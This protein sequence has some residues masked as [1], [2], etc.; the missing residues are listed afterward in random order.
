VSLETRFVAEHAFSRAAGAPLVAGNAVRL[1]R[2]ASENY[3]AWLDAIRAAKRSVLFEMYIFADDAVGARFLGAFAAKA[4]EGVAVRVAYDWVGAVGNSSRRQWR[5]LALAGV[6]VRAYNPPRL[7]EPL[8]WLSRDHRKCLVVDGEVAFVTGL[9]VGQ[10]W[11]GQP[12]RGIP[13]WRDTGVEVRGPAVADVV[14]AFADTWAASGSPLAES[15]VVSTEGQAT[16]GTVALRV[17]ATTSGTAAL[18]RLDTLVAALARKSLW[19]TDAYY[20]GTGAYVQA[21]RAAA[22]DGVDVRLLVPGRGS[23]IAIMQAVSRAGYRPLLEGGVRVFEWNGP[24]VHAKTA[25][26]DARWARVGSTNLNLA[27]WISNREL[28]V[29]IEDDAFGR[30]MEAQYLKDLENTTEVV[31]S[32]RLRV[33]AAG[34]V[35]PRRTRERRPG[36]RRSLAHRQR[37]GLRHHRSPTPR[38]CRETAHRPRRPRPRAPRA[39]GGLLAQG[40]GLARGRRLIVAGCRPARARGPRPRPN[41]SSALRPS[42]LSRAA[43]IGAGLG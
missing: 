11:E 4:R 22:Q 5:E 9:C 16:Q 31:L 33:R 13:P 35:R 15:E 3:S 43:G 38:S 21:L 42:C 17:V 18:F 25:V 8:G 12:S 26:A 34:D 19:L 36:R 23:D 20:A 27:S 6:E 32:R 10:S 30:E 7:A 29:V 28:D 14:R 40:A 37:P 39:A 1:L 24:M 41:A 2:D